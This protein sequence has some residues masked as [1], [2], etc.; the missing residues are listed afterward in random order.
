MKP[1]PPHIE[2]PKCRSAGPV[3]DIRAPMTP[4]EQTGSGYQFKLLLLRD[5]WTPHICPLMLGDTDDHETEPRATVHA[6]CNIAWMRAVGYGLWIIAS[7]EG[8]ASRKQDGGMREKCYNVEGP[9]AKA[10][11]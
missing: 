9:A 6:M 2:L 4:H 3:K 10:Q 11:N 1:Y 5:K 7:G 8:T